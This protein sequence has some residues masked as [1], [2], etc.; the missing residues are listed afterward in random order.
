LSKPESQ[1]INADE[2]RV[3]ETFVKTVL[4]NAEIEQMLI[5]DKEEE[6]EDWIVFEEEENAVSMSQMPPTER[7]Y[8]LGGVAPASH[9]EQ[10]QKRVTN[11]LKSGT[12]S[13]SSTVEEVGNKVVDK[14]NKA[15]EET[16][17]LI[18]VAEKYQNKI[19]DIV[20]LN[21]KDACL[22][23]AEL[24][25][26]SRAVCKDVESWLIKTG[27]VDHMPDSAGPC[28]CQLCWIHRYQNAA[29]LTSFKAKSAALE[30]TRAARKKTSELP[31]YSAVRRRFKSVF[32]KTESSA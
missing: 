30:V 1:K 15:G 4:M 26:R 9:W 21:Y 16:T 10:F 7:S 32:Y 6:L 5:E 29:L 27:A 17:Q 13:V 14:A 18:G 24:E 22:T 25:G 8:D 28:W 23:A 12:T 20:K 19:E 31:T 2:S 11:T 3:A